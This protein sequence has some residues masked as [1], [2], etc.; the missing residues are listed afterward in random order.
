MSAVCSFGMY[1]VHV[2]SYFV[3]VFVRLC[4]SGVGIDGCVE[5]SVRID[6]VECRSKVFGHSVLLEDRSMAEGFVAD[7][8]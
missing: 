7:V 5:I 8:A 1:N 6:A 2:F 3:S 4:V